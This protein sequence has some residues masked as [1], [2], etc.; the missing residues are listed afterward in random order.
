MTTLARAHM[1][2]GE[3]GKLGEVGNVGGLVKVRSW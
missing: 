2:V 3:P 1:R